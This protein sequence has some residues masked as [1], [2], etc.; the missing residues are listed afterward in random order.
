VDTGNNY[1]LSTTK[2]QR[3]QQKVPSGDQAVPL[4]DPKRIW[5]MRGMN[6]KE[7]TSY[8]AY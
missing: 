6:G 3:A 7:I 5:R 4:R 2:T 1:Y 8:I